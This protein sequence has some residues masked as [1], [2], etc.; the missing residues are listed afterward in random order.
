M[1]E[2]RIADPQDLPKPTYWPF[3]LAFGTTFF[4]WGLLGNAIFSF[5]GLVI[6]IIALAGWISD[7]YKELKNKAYKDGL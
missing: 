5:I 4:L 1:D 2:K 3:F 7:L 6:F